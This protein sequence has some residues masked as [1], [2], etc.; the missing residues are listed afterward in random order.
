MGAYLAGINN[1][2][3][4]VRQ[5]IA[6][7]NFLVRPFG[8]KTEPQNTEI[9]DDTSF[10]EILPVASVGSHLYETGL[11]DKHLT[12]SIATN[13]KMEISNIEPIS[14]SVIRFVAL[15]WRSSIF[16]A[17]GGSKIKH[18]IHSIAMEF[19]SQTTPKAD[20]HEIY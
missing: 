15:I 11:A 16:Q 5:A 6:V 13:F 2:P 20:I 18:A 3:L 19:M 12:F 7:R 1:F 10:L 9:R 4:W 8:L 14:G 17:L